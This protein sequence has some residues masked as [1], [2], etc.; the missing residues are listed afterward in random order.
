MGTTYS[1]DIKGTSLLKNV[2][3]STDG[4]VKNKT[5]EQIEIRIAQNKTFEGICLEMSFYIEYIIVCN[6]KWVREL[7]TKCFDPS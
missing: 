1:F 3:C 7:Q 5:F 4:M 6:C 2:Y